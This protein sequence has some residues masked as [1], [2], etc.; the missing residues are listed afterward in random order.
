MDRLLRSPRRKR[1]VRGFLAAGAT[2]L[3]LGS[4]GLGA[5]SGSGDA[6]TAVR[7]AALLRASRAVI[8]GH[9]DLINAPTPVD[10]GL[11]G[12]R[13]LAES[14]ALYRETTGEDAQ[15]IDPDS[16]AGRLMQAQMAAI[17]DVVDE[18]RDTIEAAD[19]GFKG[20]IPAT[21]ARLVNERFSERM[22]AE[23]RIKVTAP[24]P[25]VRNRTARP[26]DWEAAVIEERF[27]RPDWPRGEPFSE[28]AE[29]DGRP[30]FRFLVPEYYQPSCL[31]CHGGPA[32]EVDVT[33][34]PKEGGKA[35]D[36]GA[37]IS[38]TLFQ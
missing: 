14:L 26:D 8:S 4:L 11:T 19:L 34:Y 33:G 6:E 38:V 18:N 5:R 21:F 27:A 10:K 20:F 28:M 30:A 16:Q 31:S 23:A 36:L 7:L 15:A 22:G 3:L 12:D 1:A 29:L 35:G 17:R 32:G 2:C 37:A 13:V 25:L 9:Q 24:E